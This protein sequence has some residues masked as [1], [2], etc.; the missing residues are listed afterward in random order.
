MIIAVDFD[1]TLM[2][3]KNVLKGYRMGQPES[4]AIAAINRLVAE[5]HQIFI[6]T[7]RDVQNPSAKKAVGDWLDYFKIPYSG[8]TNIKSPHFEVFIDDLAIHFDSW[9][10]VLHHLTNIQNESTISA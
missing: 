5:G 6:F 10:Q 8:I 4:G 3:T 1:N 2:S 7:S 9:P